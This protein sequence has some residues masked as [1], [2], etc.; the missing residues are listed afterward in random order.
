[1]GEWVSSFLTAHQ[2]IIGHAYSG[3]VCALINDHVRLVMKLPLHSAT[4]K[5]DHDWMR[6]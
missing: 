2:H 5:N 4:D 6:N 3:G 1:M